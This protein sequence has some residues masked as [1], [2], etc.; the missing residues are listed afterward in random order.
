MSYRWGSSEL[1]EE[2]LVNGCCFPVTKAALDLLLARRSVWRK[3]TLW[4]DALCINQK[5]LQE[6]S[7]QVQQMRDIYHR[8]SRVIAYPGGDW[9]YRLVGSFIVQL[10]SGYSQAFPAL[11]ARI[12]FRTI[13]ASHSRTQ[14]LDNP[15][16]LTV[17]VGVVAG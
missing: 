10:V 5:D 8:A 16:M 6:K 4:I 1:T 2:I 14:V 12:L 17:D 11:R 13:S 9:R 7:E 3:R 15:Y